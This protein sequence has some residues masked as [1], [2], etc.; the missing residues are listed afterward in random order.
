MAAGGVVRGGKSLRNIH[1]CE[2]RLYF[3]NYVKSFK[4]QSN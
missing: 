2:V 1:A 3:I 4:E